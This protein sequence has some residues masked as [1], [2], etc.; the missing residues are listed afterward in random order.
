MGRLPG[1]FE[2]NLSNFSRVMALCKLGH[3]KL[4]SRISHNLFELGTLNLAS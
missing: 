2:K 4:V 3:F 1:T